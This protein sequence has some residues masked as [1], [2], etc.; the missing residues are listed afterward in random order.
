MKNILHLARPAII[1]SAIIVSITQVDARTPATVSNHT[2]Q[3]C[4]GSALP[5]PAPEV[6]PS[7][8]DSL[9][10]VMINHVGRHGARFAASPKS[11]SVIARAL[12]TADS[13]GT[14]TPAGR[15]LRE[16][17]AQVV[18]HTDGRWG[19]LDSLGRAE[20]RE[21]A[22]RMYRL[23]PQ[24]FKAGNVTAIASYVPRC[25][26]SMYAFVH[27]L[28]LLSPRLDISADAG[29]EFTPLMRFFKTDTAYLAFRESHELKH[30]FKK[31]AESALTIAPLERVLGAGFPFPADKS[32]L[33]D[34]AIAEYQLLAGLSAISLPSPDISQYFTP[35]EFNR[36]WSI[37]NMRQYLRYSRSI[38]GDTPAQAA[39]ALLADIISTTDSYVYHGA[40]APVQLRFGHAETLMPF[41]S[42]LEIAPA[43]LIS[44]NL[45]EVATRWLDFRL[46]PMA[47]NV[48]F[49]VFRAPSGRHYLRFD[50]NERPLPLIPG[51]TAIYLPL[52]KAL[53]HL[54]SLLP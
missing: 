18:H 7:Y 51:N 37:F 32:E 8:P 19:Q 3:E 4:T 25:R 43:H 15:Q 29:P 36:I 9:Q 26:A 13:L 27:E 42:L 20:Q 39:S 1:V 12:D 46:V 17:A 52:T 41:L 53:T 5:Y 31:Y 14:I 35:E 22:S 34:L 38:L 30:T 24:P 40:G 33:M 50:L 11:I 28:A 49:I 47:A 54:Q 16:I 44:N 6:T 48:R 23:F 21:I 45:D 10:P 2:W